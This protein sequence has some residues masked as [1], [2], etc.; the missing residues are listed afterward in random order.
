[1]KRIA[2]GLFCFAVNLSAAPPI[3]TDAD[4]A[5]AGTLNFQGQVTAGVTDLLT[6]VSPSMMRFGWSLLAMFAAYALLKTLIQGTLRS[7]SSHHVNHM[8]TTVA[9]VS[10]LFRILCASTMMTFYMRPLPGVP[11]NF[12]QIFPYLANALAAEINNDLLKQV[13]TQF[14]DVIHYLPSAGMFEVLPAIITVIVLFVLALA[15]V[16]MTMITA[17]SFAI[18]G[19]LTL[20]GPLLIPFY[21]LPG[22]DKRFW[23]W[24]DNMLAYSMYVFVGTGF[25]FIFCH[26][27]LDFFANL[28]SYTVGQWLVSLPYLMLITIV[29]FWSMFRVPEITHVLFGG[30]GGVAQDFASSLQGIAVRGIVAAAL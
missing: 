19:M 24:F 21:V 20:C 22:H 8:A 5:I 14:N 27:Y 16:S 25:I 7:L 26:P 28:H 23:A 30:V 10:V 4:T 29:L 18:V 2:T 13:I 9:Y 17:G 15:E 1:M 12:H 6:S 11:F 3:P